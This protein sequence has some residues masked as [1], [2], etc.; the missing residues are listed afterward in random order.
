MRVDAGLADEREGFAQAFD[1]RRQQEVAAELDEIGRGRLVAND[2]SP[3]A[4][5]RRTAAGS[6]ELGSGPAATTK[7]FGRRRRLGPAEDGAATKVCPALR[8]ASARRSERATLIVLIEIMNSAAAKRR[9]PLSVAE[10]R[11][12]H[13]RIVGKHGDE[14]GRRTRRRR[15][16][17][18]RRPRTRAP[19]PW[20]GSGCRQRQMS[21]LDE[22]QRDRRTHLAKT[23]KSRRPS[24]PPL[25]E[26]A[27]RLRGRP[28]PRTYRSPAPGAEASHA[29]GAPIQSAPRD[30]ALPDIFPVAV[31]V[32]RM[33][34]AGSADAAAPAPGAGSK[35]I[36]MI[37]GAAAP[38]RLGAEAAAGSRPSPSRPSRRREADPPRKR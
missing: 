37:T 23:N 33:D 4:D 32:E 25:L 38:A 8:C 29:H 10:K 34:D 20:R 27:A 36:L 16:R 24:C 19:P 3:L 35:S 11:G 28:E 15:F 5:A 9:E 31:V 12:F 2:E 1:H 18:P 30:L 7:S 26:T 21:R 14:T 17:R 13:R 6:A 22:V